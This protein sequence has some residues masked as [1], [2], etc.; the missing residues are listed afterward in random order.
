MALIVGIIPR[1]ITRTCGTKKM[2]GQ[3]YG[4]R[5][6]KEKGNRGISQFTGPGPRAAVLSW[7]W[8]S[9]VRVIHC[10]SC[11]RSF[12][13][14]SLASVVAVVD[15]VNLSDSISKKIVVFTRTATCTK[16]VQ[17]PGTYLC[18]LALYTRNGFEYRGRQRVRFFVCRV[19]L[20]RS[21]GACFECGHAL[22]G[23]CRRI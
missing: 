16:G 10:V 21:A 17:T 4:F 1:W 3:R 6:R 7:K 11:F 13:K 19:L 22:V 14:F 20:L 8:L 23:G 18:D 12:L 5:R 9:V 2:R 15:V